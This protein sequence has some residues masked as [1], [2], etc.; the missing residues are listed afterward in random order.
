LANLFTSICLAAT[1]TE[2]QISDLGSFNR[3][4][5][6]SLPILFA[7]GQREEANSSFVSEVADILLS[8]MAVKRYRNAKYSLQ[9]ESLHADPTCFNSV[10]FGSPSRSGLTLIPT[11]VLYI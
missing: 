6:G 1:T 11:M 8:I 3:V 5:I 9:M 4:Q 10:Y 7:L 2:Q